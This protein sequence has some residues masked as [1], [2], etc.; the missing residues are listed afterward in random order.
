MEF[1]AVGVV[2]RVRWMS[3]SLIRVVDVV[4]F[5]FGL[6]INGCGSGCSITD[7]STCTPTSLE[8]MKA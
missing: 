3:L 2:T 4:V 7:T 6:F 8:K 1:G 5:L